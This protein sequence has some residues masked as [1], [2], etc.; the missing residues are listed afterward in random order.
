MNLGTEKF[1]V[2]IRTVPQKGLGFSVS[3]LVNPYVKLGGTL[4]KPALTLDPEGVL[5]EGGAAVAT[6]GVSL[7]AKHFEERFIDAKDA[8]G[9]AVA[10]AELLQPP[11]QVAVCARGCN[12]MSCRTCQ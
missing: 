7:L 5:I 8:C 12:V 9:K 11:A 2:D 4:A 10:D 6:G 1:R 3:D